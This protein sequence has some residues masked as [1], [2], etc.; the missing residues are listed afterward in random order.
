MCRLFAMSG[1]S[2][3][4][5]ATFWLLQAPDSLAQQSRREP[6]GTGLG[7]FTP[8]GQP[9]VSKQPLAAF[10]DRDFAREAKS[11]TGRT[12]VAHV[13]FASTG[14]LTVANTHP[15]LQDGRLFAHN[16]VIGD[17]PALEHELGDDLAL[18]EGE[19]DSERFFALITREIR[20]TGDVAEGIAAAAGWV[21]AN[22]PLFAIN[23]VLI[24]PDDL[25]A[26]RYPDTH[27]LFALPRDAGGTEGTAGS[28]ALE[29]ASAKRI[30]VHSEDLAERPAVVVA[31][32][33]MDDDPGWRALDSGELL[34]VDGDLHVSSHR[35]LEGPP[36]HPLSLADLGERAAASQAGAAK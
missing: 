35:V 31:T 13:R 6:D 22:L 8:D 12:F 1:G 27:D 28:G 32:E 25:W 3:P 16:G 26:L 30:R 21:A 4:V 19:T 34:H 11:V 29:H 9:L 7:T 20:R 18:V 15:F 36:A 10:E 24:G 2:E 14:D 17:L 5:S 33:R 23:C